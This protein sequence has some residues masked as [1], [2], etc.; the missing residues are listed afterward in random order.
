M[1]LAIS[2]RLRGPVHYSKRY[3]TLLEVHAY[4]WQHLQSELQH[5]GQCCRCQKNRH[6]LPAGLFVILTL[7]GFQSL[8]MLQANSLNMKAI[9]A[10]CLQVSVTLLPRTY[11]NVQRSS[12][13]GM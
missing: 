10:A 8:S 7:W 6:L 5:T 12:C 9:D 4:R 13:A 3:R 11:Q 2:S 1:E